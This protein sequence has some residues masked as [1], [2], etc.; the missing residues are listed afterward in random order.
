MGLTTTPVKPVLNPS[1][2]TAPES[3]VGS[4]IPKPKNDPVFPNSDSSVLT[5]ERVEWTEFR[6]I[7]RI[8]AK[9]GVRTNLLPRVAVKELVDNALDTNS[10]VT[11]GTLSHSLSLFTFFVHDGGAGIDGSDEELARRY[12]VRRPL[13][14]SKT[15]RNITRG[16][17]GNGTRVVAGVVLVC[18]GELKVS[19]RGRT[20]TLKPDRDSGETRIVAVQPWDGK[21]TRVEVTLRA[22]MARLACADHDLFSWAAEA[23][24]LAA[25]EPYKGGRSSFHWYDPD[26]LWELLQSAPEECPVEKLVEKLDG[27]SDRHRLEEVAGPLM[28]LLCRSATRLQA[29]ALLAR[30][31]QKTRPVAPERLGKVGKRDDFH[32]Y[33]G[34]WA[35]TYRQHGVD[36]PFVIEVWANRADE[37][38]A[39]V[40]VN[41]TPV[42]TAVH[43][44]R[45]QETKC[46]IHGCG[47]SHIVQAGAKRCGEFRLLVN[48]TAPFVPLTSSGKDPNLLPL[49][50]E[51]VAACN[52]AIRSAKTNAPKGRKKSQK[53]IIR[54]RIKTAAEE[55]SGGGKWLFSL[56]QL[57]YHLRKALIQA[58][59]CEPSYGTF[60]RIVG[61]YEDECGDIEDMYRDDRG[62]LYVPHTG[63]TIQLGTCSV[64]AYERPP[65][66]FRA[67]LYSEKEGLFPI[68]KHAKWPERYDC[69]LA[70]AKGFA[71][72]AI[73]EL[74]RRMKG[75]GEPVVFF[76]IH[77]ADGPG[78]TI[79]E[80]LKNK[81]APLGITIINLGLD[82][83]EGRR[84]GLTVEPVK[85]K[86]GKRVPVGSYLPD[87]DQDWL[88]GNR[89]ELNAM[90]PEVFLDWLSRKFEEHDPGKVVPP[91]EAIADRMAADARHAMEERIREQL[92]REAGF[93]ARVDAAMT[94]LE[95]ALRSNAKSLAQTLPASL[96][97]DPTRHWSHVVRDAAHSAIA[98]SSKDGGAA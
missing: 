78:T 23:V 36:I 63:E 62:S 86:N 1:G 35:G 28:G 93:T 47:L 66:A 82:P 26:A 37:P 5:F 29:T 22:E 69:A 54:D 74:L 40:C 64:A 32:G 34:K 97:T 27:C 49:A 31:K 46:S 13:T 48:V 73:K 80:S 71:T 9:A 77:D 8:S 3:K 90:T 51:I 52:K 2:K 94:A 55:L 20:L 6:D 67:V 44:T 87:D 33:S 42:V 70:T 89:I 85:K 59:G 96:A 50:D 18:D 91:A 84:M 83:D 81:L 56:R 79:Y 57:F 39:T 88:Q 76:I 12:S 72:R 11:Y 95:P 60:S 25:G 14:S 65:W 38:S 68:L 15:L 92:L 24:S 41:R 98:D 43:F 53:R 21:G 10:T 30:A 19:T 16:M 61:T 7:N 17:L 58:I 45:R 4:E 75:T